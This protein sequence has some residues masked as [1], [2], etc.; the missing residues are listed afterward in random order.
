M[1]I[2]IIGL[3]MVGSAV[4]NGFRSVPSVEV[5]THD[6]KFEG[7]KIDAVKD[8]DVCF[9][10]LPTNTVNG[11]QDQMPLLDC[12]CALHDLHY[13][14]EV[15]IKSTVLPGSCEAFQRIYPDLNINHNPE[16]LSERTAERDF[17][18]QKTVLISGKSFSKTMLAY[19]LLLGSDVEFCLHWDMK[20]TEWA[21]YAHN[22][23]LAV[24]LS[25]LN[26]LHHQIGEQS[27]YDKAIES[28][29]KFGNIP[30]HHRCPGPDGNLGWSGGCFPKDTEA[31]AKFAREEM[32]T[33]NAAI[34][35]N[36]RV[37]LKEYK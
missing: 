27:I 6:I 28:A 2:G 9:M 17:M 34:E 23:S 22:C 11:Q 3:G 10:C 18:N 16:F 4:A 14:G 30:R 5:S 15:S 26:E 31:L 36:K 20:V 7:S 21:K 29:Y 12:L 1:K 25:F 35:S 8:T 19:T 13:T 24:S 33:L 37:R 32:L